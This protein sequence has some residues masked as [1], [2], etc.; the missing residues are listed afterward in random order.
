VDLDPRPRV[1][2]QRVAQTPARDHQGAGIHNGPDRVIAFLNGSYQLSFHVMLHLL[3][4]PAS[5]RD[6]IGDRIGDVG[7]G[8]GAVDLGLTMPEY[9]QVR[10]VQQQ[11]F[12]H[13]ASKVTPPRKR[14]L[15]ASR[16]GN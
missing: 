8:L 16:A 12:A 3:D 2:R 5:L 9:A 6:L 10:A 15:H 1:I 13:L 7:Q 14:L 4:F 11:Q